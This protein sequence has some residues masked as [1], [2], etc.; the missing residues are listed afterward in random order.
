MYKNK[1]GHFMVRD[2]KI[3]QKKKKAR[4]EGIKIDKAAQDDMK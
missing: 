3:G 1:D 2:E 4:W